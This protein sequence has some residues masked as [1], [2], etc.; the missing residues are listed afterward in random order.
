MYAKQQIYNS[1]RWVTT[2]QIQDSRTQ[3]AAEKALE[4]GSKVNANRHTAF[5]RTRIDQ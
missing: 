2:M 4:K 5:D 3:T 1:C